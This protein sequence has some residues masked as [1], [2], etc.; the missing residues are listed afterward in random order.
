MTT[1]CVGATLEPEHN[2]QEHTEEDT[3]GLSSEPHHEDHLSLTTELHQ[4]D[5]LSLTTELHHEDHLSLTTELHHEDH[6]NLT[7]EL[8]HE[9]PLKKPRRKDTPVLNSPPHIPGVRQMK[10]EKNTVYLED[11]EKDVGD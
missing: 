4:E 7:A 10:A 8:H 9:D 5:H 2:F 1:G 11:Q 6:L 3:E